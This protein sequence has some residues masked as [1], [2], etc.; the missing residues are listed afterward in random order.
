MSKYVLIND[1]GFKV[2]EGQT[3]SELRVSEL[4]DFV[5]EPIIDIENPEVVKQHNK[6]TLT[7]L[8]LDSKG[9]AIGRVIEERSL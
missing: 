1:A 5:V 7:Y 2:D 3:L 8:V 4:G 9:M 6:E